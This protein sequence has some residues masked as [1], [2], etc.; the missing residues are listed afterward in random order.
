MNDTIP[1]TASSG[2][3]FYLSRNGHKF[4]PYSVPELQA[5]GRAGQLK[6]HTQLHR[7]TDGDLF[8]ARDIPW[9]F[10]D[11]SWT[12]AVLLAVFL[13]VFGVDR[14]YLGHVWLGLAKIFTVGGF[15]LWALVDV[16]LI[17]LRMVRDSEG[18]RCDDA[19]TNQRDRK[20]ED[21]PR[22]IAPRWA[23]SSNRRR[24]GVRRSLDDARLD[25]VT[26]R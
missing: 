19:V 23:S 4:G 17:G 26:Q 22:H 9:V 3:A 10:S 11:K 16:V 5:M 18:G 13:G 6:A 21:G 8:A 24:R 7:T 12:V 2:E 25:P 15:G 1:R 20:L 14:L